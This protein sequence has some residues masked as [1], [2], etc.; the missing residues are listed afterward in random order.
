M[1]GI[2]TSWGESISNKIAAAQSWP[3]NR[4]AA[5]S[6]LL[7]VVAWTMHGVIAGAGR[8]LHIDVLEAYAWGKEFQLG[9][10]PHPPF[11]AWIAGAWFLVF[12]VNNES[13]ILLEAINSALGLWGAW[14]LAGLFARDW[15]RHAAVLML[16]ATPFYTVMA[17]KFNANTIFVSLWPWTAFFFVRSL[18]RMKARDAAL[19]GAF[20]A[21]CILSKYY[22]AILLMTC[23][24]SLFFHPNGRK[25]VFSPLPW[26]A[27]AVFA[28]AVL[29]HVLWALRSDLTPA[30]YAAAKTGNG[31]AY[32]IEHMARFVLDNTLH[33][34]GPLVL[35]LVAWRISKARPLH[36]PAERPQQSR[37]RFLAVIVLAPPLLTMVFALGF[38]LKIDA[39][40]AAGI[41]P[42]MPL[43]LM[44]Y[45]SPL[46]ERLCF[47]LAGAVALAVTVG[48]VPV[49]PIEGAVLGRKNVLPQRE[50]AAAVT[51]LWHAGTHTP[52]R[53]AGGRYLHAHAINFYSEDHPSS[54][55]ELQYPR[56]PW[57]TPEKIKKYGLLIACLHDNSDCLARAPEVLSGSWKQY[58]ISVGRVIGTRG[59]RRKPSISSL[60]RR[61]PPSR[62]RWLFL[63]RSGGAAIA[64]PAG[65]A[66]PM[67]DFTLAVARVT[68]GRAPHGGTGD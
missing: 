58:S 21:A 50:L 63:R 67:V 13:F 24:L 29:P 20:A 51:A 65:A 46:D 18:D 14:M 23:G 34:A 42:L 25:Y 22:A 64:P 27:A 45:V 10:Y 26:I 59:F 15:T 49:A 36:E 16:L 9:Y 32:A 11:W 2:A 4:V 38:Q 39:D 33:F 52:L 37:R 40:M 61:N 55:I 47:R 28:A 56:S 66:S 31:S 62:R 19:F 57:V 6:L 8:A 35:L 53:Y 41:F 7:F 12:P 43:F 30:T 68:H 3:A 5:G 1:S 48:S 17:F 44:Q 60:C 54:F